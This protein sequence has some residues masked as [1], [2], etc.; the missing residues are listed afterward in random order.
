MRH[1]LT[2]RTVDLGDGDEK[3]AVSYEYDEK[4]NKT[5]DDLWER[6]ISDV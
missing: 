1:G 5:K 3:I 6:S 2:E 4:G